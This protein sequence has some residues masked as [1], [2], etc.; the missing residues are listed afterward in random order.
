MKL[1]HLFFY[2]TCAW[3]TIIVLGLITIVALCGM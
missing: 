3:L 1:S 2:W